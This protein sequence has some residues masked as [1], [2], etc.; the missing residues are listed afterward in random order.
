M[1]IEHF[2]TVVWKFIFIISLIILWYTHYCRHSR[3]MWE[4]EKC[5]YRAVMKFLTLEKQSA[6][7]IRERLTNMYWNCAPSYMQ[8]P[9]DGSLNL[10]VA[11]HDW[12]MTPVL[13]GQLRRPQMIVAMLSQ[14]WWREIHE[15][16]LQ[17]AMEVGISNGS[18]LNILLDR[19]V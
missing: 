17:I 4:I 3:K 18:V 14:Y 5:E 6:N 10:N 12:K 8:M 1:F 13:D 19:L 11:E 2:T 16:V 15:W 9:L 7:N